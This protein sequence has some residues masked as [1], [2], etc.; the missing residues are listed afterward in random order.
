MALGLAGRDFARL[1][2]PTILPRLAPQRDDVDIVRRG[3]VEID[4]HT[5]HEVSAETGDVAVRLLDHRRGGINAGGDQPNGMP[6][7]RQHG[8]GGDDRERAL[9]PVFRPC[10]AVVVNQ[11]GLTVGPS[12]ARKPRRPQ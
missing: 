10:S 5:A 12:R 11:Q 6:F 3:R 7:C 1:A 2:R 4:E 9:M 8:G